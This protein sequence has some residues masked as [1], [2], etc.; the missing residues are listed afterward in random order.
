VVLTLRAELD[1]RQ[2]FRTDLLSNETR[3]RQRNLEIVAVLTLLVLALDLVPRKISALGVELDKPD[4]RGILWALLIFVCAFAFA[5]VI[6]ALSDLAFA[7]ERM[8]QVQEEIDQLELQPGERTEW[9]K[10]LIVGDVTSQRSL[11]EEIHNQVTALVVEVS[12]IRNLELI[13]VFGW[14]RM[15]VEFVVPLSLATWAV[16]WLAVRLS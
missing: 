15:A 10:R 3:R 13:R 6:Y 4:Q 11:T 14:L 7:R 2:T 5:F 16:I 1:W 8:G 12:R 9:I